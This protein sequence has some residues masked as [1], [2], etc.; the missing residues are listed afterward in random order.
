MNEYTKPN[1]LISKCIEFD[2]CRYNGDMISSDIIKRL[3]PYVNFK[4]VCP[5][6]EDLKDSGKTKKYR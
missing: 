2:Y 5:E 1:I 3:K 4:A 6:L